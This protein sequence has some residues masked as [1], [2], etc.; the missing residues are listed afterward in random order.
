MSGIFISYRRED[1]LPYAGRLFDHLK[2]HFG[3]ENVF[4]DVD[5]IEPGLDF[6]QVLQERVSSCDALIAVIGRRWLTA[7][8]NKGQRRLDDPEDLV[9][10]EI[11]AALNR[12]VRVVPTLVGGA[13]MPRAEELPE[14]IASLSRRNALEISDLAFNSSVG[15]LIEALEK[16]VKQT[17][18]PPMAKE[19]SPHGPRAVPTGAPGEPLKPPAYPRPAELQNQ[20]AGA[21][22]SSQIGRGSPYASMARWRRVLL[23]YLPHGAFEWLLMG[24]ISRAVLLFVILC[25]FMGADTALTDE[26][27]RLANWSAVL[28]FLVTTVLLRNLAAWFDRRAAAR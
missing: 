4:M 3:D 12:Q 8:D 13:D 26:S 18:S 14:A 2:N 22:F 15:R 25:A 27:D 24:W 9:R 6:V 23:L 5:N 16:I 7:A 20:P 11:G 1:S 10:L 21:R 28:F 17:P 19:G